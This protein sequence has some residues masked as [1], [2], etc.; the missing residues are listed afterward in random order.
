MGLE[1]VNLG[2]LIGGHSFQV[3]SR[4]AYNGLS[5]PTSSLTD[6]GANGYLFIDTKLAIELARFFNRRLTRLPLPSRTR[7][8]DGNPGRPVTHSLNLHLWV[9]GRRFLD[10]PFLIVDLG[11]YDI[12]IGRRW[13]A[14]HDI[15]LDV[16]NR[17]M[18]WQTDRTVAEEVQ[19]KQETVV[20][21]RILPRPAIQWEHQRDADR[22]DRLMAREAVETGYVRPEK[23]RPGGGD[24]VWTN[25][26]VEQMLKTKEEQVAA[27]YS[28]GAG[29]TRSSLL[30]IAI[31]GASPLRRLVKKKNSQTFV[32]S[33]WEIDR[34]IE[35]KRMEERHDE[36]M[37]EEELVRQTLPKCYRGYEDVFSR[38]A[39][40]R[41]PPHRHNDYIIVLND[42]QRPEQ[43]IGYSPLFKHSLQELEEMHKYIVDNLSKGFVESSAAPFASPILMV[44]KAD[45]GI[46]FAWIIDG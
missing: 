3:P 41:L 2:K 45:G 6:T 15:W 32:T 26:E 12:I 11:Q 22:R 33:L 19:W 9:D 39:S 17:R 16:R 36:E 30:D 29:Q 24:R 27:R 38:A 14:N 34:V 13:L 23:P 5:V 8:F 37:A 20:P 31:L 40:D 4:V 43:T 35:K 25:D 7:G 46:D 1:E 28:R 21:K 42:G 10:Q 18:I 44:R